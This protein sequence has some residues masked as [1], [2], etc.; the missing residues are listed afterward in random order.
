MERANETSEVVEENNAEILTQSVLDLN[1]TEPFV[2][3][4]VTSPLM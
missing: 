2:D 4:L 1:I 3:L